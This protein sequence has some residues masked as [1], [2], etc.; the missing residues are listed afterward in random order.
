[1]AMLA[2]LSKQAM[3]MPLNSHHYFVLDE[4]D[5]L[6]AKAMPVLKSVM[7]MP[8]CVFILT[9]NH[10]GA[11]EVGVRDRCHC[12]PFNAAPAQE[13]LPLAKRIMADAG[14]TGITD[15]ALVDVIATGNGSAR[16]IT[17]ALISVVLDSYAAN[18]EL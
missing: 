18:V 4:V 9:T 3:F 15:Q 5:N 13:W 17:D 12:I 6:S 1:M 8:D 10:F 7:N 11:V 2:S 14:V 16:L